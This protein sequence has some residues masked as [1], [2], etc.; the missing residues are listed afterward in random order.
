MNKP[1]IIFQQKI[2]KKP[3]ISAALIVK[4]CEERI[5]DCL[6]SI[7]DI[8]DEIVIVDD[9]SKD[10]SVNYIKE[11]SNKVS[12]IVQNKLENFSLQRNIGLDLCSGEYN[13][14]IDDDERVS[15]SLKSGILIL[16]SNRLD[17]EIYFCQRENFNFHGSA[18]EIRRPFLIRKNIRFYGDIHEKV[19]G[20]EGYVK[21]LL[22]HYSDPSI[23]SFLTDI[24]DYSRLK[25]ISW[26][27]EG[28]KYPI[29][30]L[31]PRQIGV[32]IFLL[33]K[34]LFF[35]RRIKDGF[36]ALIYCFAWMAEEFFVAMWYIELQK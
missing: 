5:F 6:K 8:V 12:I 13:L 34:R 24:R 17:K 15:S 18:I 30:I 21:G 2:T 31:F 20:S 36:P 26:L 16:L 25:A 11:I 28:R 23:F 9:C 7:E 32:A 10:N 3:F 33:I 4:D 29:H 27:K 14:I 35:E 22:S 1:N 19:K